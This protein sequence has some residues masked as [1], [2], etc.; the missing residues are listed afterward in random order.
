MNSA[1]S[2]NTTEK[3]HKSETTNL[4]SSTQPPRTE[5]FLKGFMSKSVLYLDERDPKSARLNGSIEEIKKHQ[6]YSTQPP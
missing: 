2:S 4:N 5:S 3:Q 6:D 1:E